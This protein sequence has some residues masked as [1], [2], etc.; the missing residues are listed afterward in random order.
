[1]KEI[2]IIIFTIFACTVLLITIACYEFYQYKK[3]IARK[4][5]IQND[6]GTLMQIL[7]ATIKTE[8]D[9][10]E[11]DIFSNK[12]GITNSNF[13]NYYND[14]CL[15]IINSLSKQFIDQLTTYITY[16]TIIR[17]IARSVKKYLSEKVNGTF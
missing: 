3:W 8:L 2:I 14:L 16:E 4:M 9:L 1:M 6:F 17:Y 5:P 11:D 15:R 7:T 10:Y 13:D 12:G